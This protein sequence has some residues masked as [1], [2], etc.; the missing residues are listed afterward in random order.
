MDF[1]VFGGHK[2]TSDKILEK[3]KK[4]SK[5]K[6]SLFTNLNGL[7]IFD[8][9][10]INKNKINL[11]ETN[12]SIKMKIN[13]QGNK[14][15]SLKLP[16]LFGNGEFINGNGS[17]VNDF[18][19]SVGKP[20]F[21]N[22]SLTNIFLSFQRNEININKTNIKVNKTEFTSK[23]NKGTLKVGTEFVKDTQTNYVRFI[24]EALGFKGDIKFG[25]N[26]EEKALPFAKLAIEKTIG[27]KFRNLFFE[28]TIQ[29]GQIFGH[30]TLLDRFFLGNSLPGYKDLSVG[31]VSQNNKVGGK[32]IVEIKNKAGISIRNISIFGFADA[33]AN[34]SQGLGDCCR[35]LYSFEDTNCIGKSVGVGVSFRD[36]KGPS[37]LFAVP[38]T[39]N[40]EAEKYSF[41]VD[42]QF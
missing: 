38:M 15:F 11:N 25:F 4:I 35:V 42:Y 31:P 3:V 7:E 37:L 23:T 28:S 21:Y 33:G 10:E 27:L 29:V 40:T 41:T 2:K 32:S 26:K 39:S 14:N 5:S 6:D 36:K 34:V 20:V 22:N 16:N 30:T 19:V 8:S 12:N 17:G 13:S 24:T 18:R 1:L 9:F